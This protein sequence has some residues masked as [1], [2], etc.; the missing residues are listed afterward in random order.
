MNDNRMNNQPIRRYRRQ[1]GYD[2]TRTAAV[3]IMTV[4]ILIGV[5]VF[6]MS[7]TGTGL[8]ADRKNPDYVGGPAD[9]DG[10]DDL[11]DDPTQSESSEEDPPLIVPAD[12]VTYEYLN[13]TPAEIKKGDLLLVDATHP[14][15][16]PSVQ[17]ATIYGNKSSSYKVPNSSVSL[18]RS[19]ID[20]V[21]A[22][23]D[24]FAVATGMKDAIV[25]SAYRSFNDQK[26]LHDKYPETAAIPGCSDYHI[27]TSLTFD[28]YNETGISPMSSRSE[29]IWLKEN[30]HRYGFTFRY[31]ADK[32]SITGYSVPWQ[33]RYVGSPHATY[34]YDK[35]LCLEEYLT[36]LSEN[37]KYA[38]EHLFV[39]CADGYIYE[40]FY[41]EGATE[42]VI[43]VPVP[44]NREYVL[45]GDNVNGFI[46]SF[47]VCEATAD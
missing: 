33:M 30:A 31:P 47:P 11:T 26:A 13:L 15:T 40:V 25:Q 27:G 10:T 12:D 32:K 18:K 42:G 34:M 8:F 1:K 3:L 38:D 44:E 19:V 17:M 39:E 20:E 7:L 9:T 45:S 46:V 37:H 21:N 43:Q 5:V 28:V 14:Y 35:F 24:A 29:S 23:M 2:S 16:F 41:V 4:I 6:I 22:M 36:L